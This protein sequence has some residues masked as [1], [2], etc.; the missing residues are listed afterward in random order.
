MKLK[1]L[2]AAVALAAAAGSQAATWDLALADFETSAN[3]TK[4]VTF[5]GGSAIKYD[6]TYSGIGESD[7]VLGLTLGELKL[8]SIQDIAFTSIKL[9]DS[10]NVVVFSQT[11]PGPIAFFAVDSLTITPSFS[12]ILEGAVVGTGAIKGSYDLSVTAAP[13]PEPETYALM[14]AGLGAVG[15]AAARRRA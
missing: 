11:P 5:S 4:P 13:I 6:F 7:I 15:F 9:V 1:I 12:L 8:G 3:F 2:A 14:L 10:N